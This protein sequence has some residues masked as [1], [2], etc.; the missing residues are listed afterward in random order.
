M[1]K[2]IEILWA[3]VIAPSNCDR[4]SSNNRLDVFQSDDPV[5]IFIIRHTFGAQVDLPQ[6]L[7]APG[8]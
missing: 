3:G 1:H 6:D 5:L 8:S 4:P 2:K 7:D